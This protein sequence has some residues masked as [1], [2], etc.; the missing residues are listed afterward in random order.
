MVLSLAVNRTGLMRAT[1]SH[2]FASARFKPTVGRMR[3]VP[4]GHS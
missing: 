2:T 1:P 4:R 3:A